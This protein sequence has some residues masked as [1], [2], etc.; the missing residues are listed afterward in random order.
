[1]AERRRVYRFRG[2]VIAG[3]NWKP[4]RLFDELPSLRVCDLCRM[5][6]KRILVLPCSHVLC[7]ACHA[8]SFQNGADGLCPLD[9][10]PF[11][12]AECSGHDFPDNKAKALKVHCWN[13]VHGCEFVGA[14]EEILTHY[15]DK[16]AFHI[17]ECFRC[18]E[19]VFH[20]VLTS[21]YASGC[22]AGLFSK[23]TTYNTS[24]STA[25]VAQYVKTSVEQMTA[26]LTNPHHDR[27]MPPMQSK[28]NA[29]TQQFRRHKSQ[30]AEFTRELNV[31]S[32]AERANAA[33]AILTSVADQPYYENDPVEPASTTPLRMLHLEKS[34]TCRQPSF[35]AQLPPDVLK[36]MRQTS[37][38]DYPQ[39]VFTNSGPQDV[40]CHL[41]LTTHLSMMNSWTEVDVAVKYNLT[42]KNCDVN[43]SVMENSIIFA[44]LTVLHTKDAYFTVD[45][46]RNYLFLFVRVEFHGKLAGSRVFMPSLRV[47]VFNRESCKSLHLSSFQEPCHCKRDDDWLLHFRRTFSIEVDHLQKNDCLRGRKMEFEIEV[48]RNKTTDSQRENA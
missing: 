40:K 38:Q 8:V 26:L 37:S 41:K 22:T 14:M 21:H 10:E 7:Q 12:G 34:K 20:S 47:K 18:G 5:I 16:C 31:S 29:P 1:M 30:S 24:E 27:L 48:L 3:M 9:G 23:D 42:L 6:P 36:A 17:V 45:I 13:E 33:A 15:E 35:F 28:L 19:E 25:V 44:Q 32:K 46:S 2:H 39:H 11:V 43:M 4:T